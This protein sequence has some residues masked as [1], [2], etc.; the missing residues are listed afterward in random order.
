VRYYSFGTASTGGTW[1]I[2]GA[3]L[4]NHLNR[5]L[6][7]I[8]V[9][10]EITA[11][12]IEDYYLLKRGQI[13]FAFSKPDIISDDILGKKFGGV[14]K[15]QIMQFMWSDHINQYH[16][17]VREGSP[18]ESLKDV[19]GKKFAIGPHSSSTQVMTRRLLKAVYGY[20]ADKGYD[21]LYYTFE[22][23]Q[24]ALQDGN[25]DIC[26]N[27]GGSPVGSLINLSTIM[28]VHFIPVSDSEL[29]HFNEE[30]PG[31]VVRTVIPKGT[32]KNQSEDLRTIGEPTG[33]LISPTVP[34]DDVYSAFKA[35][36]A[37]ISERNTVHPMIERYTIEATV[38]YGQDI[39]RL[40]VPFHPGVKRYLKEIGKWNENLETK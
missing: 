7:D 36:F 31:K 13:D 32:Y 11:G 6:S 29:A 25:A 14:S 9:T 22:D 21:A 27:S 12:A 26:H 38:T 19:K 40:G 2:V 3:G 5:Q 16:Y 15:G 17:V 33:I 28:R 34:E 37:A 23:G 39:S 10:A 4:C 30:W 8:K 35:L 20:E 18:I 24:R 1:Y